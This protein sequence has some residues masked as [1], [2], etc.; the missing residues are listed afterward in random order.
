MS[1]NIVEYIIIDYSIAYRHIVIKYDIIPCVYVC[2]RIYIYIYIYMRKGRCGAQIVGI[3]YVEK[4][5]FA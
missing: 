2:I 3:F 5:C 1:Y 4:V